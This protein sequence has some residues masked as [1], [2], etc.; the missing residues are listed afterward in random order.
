MSNLCMIQDD[1]TVYC[2][3]EMRANGGSWNPVTTSWMF[4]NE[5]DK[6]NALCDLYRA[7]RPTLAMRETLAE[8]IADGTGAQAWG[9][10]P[11]E[12]PV[13]VNQLDRA[14]ASKMLAAG[15]AVRRVLGIHPLEDAEQ[16]PEETVFD[17]SE[18]ETRA[19]ARQQ[20]RRRSAA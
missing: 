11:A 14:E 10:D 12:N 5:S 16:P 6:A 20:R 4:A 17:A 9:F 1:R 2:R 8:M 13:E 18:F 3:V 19:Q 15:F 7:T